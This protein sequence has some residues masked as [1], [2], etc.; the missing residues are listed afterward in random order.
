MIHTPGEGSLPDMKTESSPSLVALAWMFPAAVL[1]TALVVLER[2]RMLRRT[3]ML[4][5]ASLGLAVVV[6]WH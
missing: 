1:Y 5:A 4:A 6:W 3:A 2:S